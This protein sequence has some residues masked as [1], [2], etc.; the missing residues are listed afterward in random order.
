MVKLNKI[1]RNDS[2]KVKGFLEEQN[3]MTSQSFR[4]HHG[5][6]WRRRRDAWRCLEMSRG[7]TEMS[8][9]VWRCRGDVWECRG[10]V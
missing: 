3:G 8:G 5:Y 2:L 1:V 4:R 9:D 10:D 6:R 7:C